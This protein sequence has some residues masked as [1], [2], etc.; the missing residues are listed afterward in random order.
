MRFAARLAVVV[1]L[2]LTG[3]LRA[4]EQP[5]P[6]VHFQAGRVTVD[7][8]LEAA[9]GQPRIHVQLSRRGKIL[10]GKNPLA[11]LDLGLEEILGDAAGPQET[12]LAYLDTGASAFVL[13]QSTA[14]RFG[15]QVLDHAVYHE[16]G[17]HGETPMGVTHPYRLE[18]A[19]S[20]GMLNDQP[21]EKRH[22]ISLNARMQVNRANLA[23]NTPGG[24]AGGDAEAQ[25]MLA[26][27]TEVNVIGMPAIRKYVVE[28]DPSPMGNTL[29]GG[30]DPNMR[31]DPNA[32]LDQLLGGVQDIGA[33][34]AVRLHLPDAMPRDVDIVIPLE[35]VDY[36]RR[37]NPKDRGD[38]P[39]LAPN[40]MIRNV[41]TAVGRSSFRGD[42]LLDTGA[43]VTIISTKH[44]RALGIEGKQPQFTLPI[45]GIGGN[46]V[47]APGYLI[48]QLYVPGDNGDQLLYRNCRT[49]VHDI[50]IT[51]DDGT[52][53]VLDGVFGM[54]LLLP[55]MAGIGLGLPT[56]VA[57][58]PFRKIWIG[59]PNGKLGLNVKIPPP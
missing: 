23:A 44:A 49:I 28:I 17:L 1:L 55:T 13:S 4:R 37:R 30:L 40:P 22:L 50:G 8:T 26:A 21:G 38:K 36:N 2:L 56:D 25:Q 9:V 15:V 29:A 5:A 33:G 16:V 53:V 45:G 34:P 59:G 3:A 6:Q 58:A 46:V 48:D 18:L 52:H 11:G 24:N 39:D 42:F 10:K 57:D 19:D 47:N 27:M 41:I 54:N 35:Y 31:V 20:S 7:N 43:T 12:F 51:L 14:D 32:P